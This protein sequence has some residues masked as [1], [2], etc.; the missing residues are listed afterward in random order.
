MPLRDLLPV[1]HVLVD[2]GA[3]D[4]AALLHALSEK[5]AP[6]AGV[7]AAEVERALLARE[8]LGSTG[9]GAGI[10]LPHARTA[11]VRGNCAVFARL[12][13][14]VDFAAIDG[15]PVD[16]VCAIVSPDEPRSEALTALSAVSKVLRSAETVARVRSAP[17]AAGVHAAL[18][19]AGMES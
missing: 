13:A 3:T 16:I 1:E 4:K 11:G 2:L 17:D 7:S 18:V 8:E 19:G 9:I 6:H 15:A 14:P 12:A 10:A 5:L